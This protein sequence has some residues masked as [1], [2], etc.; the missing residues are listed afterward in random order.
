MLPLVWG[1]VAGVVLYWTVYSHTAYEMEQRDRASIGQ[2]SLDPFSVPEVDPWGVA[3][4]GVYVGVGVLLMAQ[5][6]P[7]GKVAGFA[8]LVP[9]P[10]YFAA[11]TAGVQIGD[12]VRS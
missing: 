7:A 3:G 8:I 9:G 11:Y 5:P 12:I 2:D 10:T 6:I 4:V 1:V